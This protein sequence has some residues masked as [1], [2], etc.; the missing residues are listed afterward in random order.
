MASTPPTTTSLVDRF[1]AWFAGISDRLADHFEDKELLAELDMRV[2][3]LGEITWELGPGLRQE[4]ALTLTPDGDPQLLPLAERIIEA[5]PELSRWEFHPARQKKKWDLRFSVTS[6][7]G[8]EIPVDA[9]SWRYVLLGFPDSTYDLILEQPNLR[10]SSEEDRYTAAVI[11]VDGVL[12]EK[13]RLE[14]IGEISPTTSLTP[15][16]AQSSTNIAQLADHLA[17][18]IS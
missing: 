9:R 18:L 1:W 8:A 17:S 11:V 2:S 3:E 15:E 4:C 14:Y 5:A 6:S 7:E 12:G 10:E 13:D 16:H